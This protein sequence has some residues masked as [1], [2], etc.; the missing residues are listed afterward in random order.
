MENA[1]VRWMTKVRKAAFTL[2]LA[3][4]KAW[5]DNPTNNPARLVD[6]LIKDADDA[7]RLISI[8]LGMFVVVTAML[9]VGLVWAMLLGWQLT[10]VG[11][12]LVPIFAGAMTLQTQLTSKFQLRNKRAREE[13]SKVS[14]EVS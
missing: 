3:Q 1:A 5:F 9:I 14:Y 10:L 7:K 8:C 11:I 12:A 6:V 2:V 13:V 4:D